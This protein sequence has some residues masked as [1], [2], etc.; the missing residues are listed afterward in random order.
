MSDNTEKF[1]PSD[2]HWTISEFKERVTKPQLRHVLLNRGEPIV[3]GRVKEWKHRKVGPNVYEIW[4]G[5]K[6][7]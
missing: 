3:S 5:D 6:D 1:K 2:S 7:E 4:I